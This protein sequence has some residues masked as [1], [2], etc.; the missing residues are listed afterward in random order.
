MRREGAFPDLGINRPVLGVGINA[1]HC[2]NEKLLP[3]L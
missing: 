2:K 1:D 3:G